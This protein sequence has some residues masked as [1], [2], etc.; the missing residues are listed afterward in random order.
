MSMPKTGQLNFRA[1]EP[2]D[3]H[4]L[5]EWENDP[6]NWTTGD[7]QLPLSRE[8]YENYLNR[9][10]ETLEQAGQ[11]RWVIERRDDRL[12]VGL[13]DIYDYSERHQRASV[14]ILIGADFRGNGYA[15][16]ALN[17]LS[18]YATDIANLHQLFAE[19]TSDNEAS[20]RLFTSCGYRQ[21]GL[22]R[23]W[24]RRNTGFHDVVQLQLM[25]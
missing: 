22:L 5:M 19:I 20:L 21:T 14:G 8:T 12:P 1:L 13:L 18:A 17:W 15:S 7:R 16:E 2:S 3:L 24:V 9:A 11:Y 10:V 6:S 4:W 23:D 25:L